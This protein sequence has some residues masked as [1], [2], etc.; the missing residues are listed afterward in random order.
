MF[1]SLVCLKGIWQLFRS[2]PVLWMSE[3]ACVVASD[4]CVPFAY[5]HENADGG[6]SHLSGIALFLWNVVAKKSWCRAVRKSRGRLSAVSSLETG[7]GGRIGVKKWQAEVR[8][9]PA[10][11]CHQ[12]YPPHKPWRYTSWTKGKR[13]ICLFIALFRLFSCFFVV[14]FLLNLLISFCWL[15]LWILCWVSEFPYRNFLFQFYS[16]FL[17]FSFFNISLCSMSIDPLLA[18]LF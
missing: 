4:K 13:R 7:E 2:L 8:S 15:L 6:I 5:P 17:F 16:S 14:V 11:P 18:F 10:L 3:H 1:V 9:R 12:F